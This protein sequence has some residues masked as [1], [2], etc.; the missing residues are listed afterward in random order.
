MFYLNARRL[1]TSANVAITNLDVTNGVAVNTAAIQVD[2]NG[3]FF[4]LLATENKAGGAG[5]V[6]IYPEY[7]IDGT[8]WYRAYTTSGGTLTQESNVVTALQNVSRWVVFTARLAKYIRFV[9]DPDADSTVTL[10]FIYSEEN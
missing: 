2:K 5:D 9:I 7:S 1:F 3:G 4:T 8:N 6:D 10:D